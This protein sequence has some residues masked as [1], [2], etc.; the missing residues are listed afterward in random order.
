MQDNSQPTDEEKR[1][2]AAELV[3]RTA[4]QALKAMRTLRRI[5]QALAVSAMLK[6]PGSLLDRF[7]AQQHPED[8][9]HLA[10]LIRQH[11]RSMLSVAPAVIKAIGEIP[12]LGTDFF[13]LPLQPSISPYSSDIDAAIPGMLA[14]DLALGD[15]VE[16]KVADHGTKFVIPFGGVDEGRIVA[17]DASG[18]HEIIHPC[19]ADVYLSVDPRSDRRGGTR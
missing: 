2:R 6:A 15:A 10:R 3:I 17:V 13:L 5:H 1:R 9:D 19:E 12:V 16:I 8:T 14:C 18:H 7:M 11:V 4:H